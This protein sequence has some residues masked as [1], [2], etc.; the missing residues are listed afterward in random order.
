VAKK[1]KHQPVP[2]AP[3]GPPLPA[4]VK[5][6]VAFLQARTAPDIIAEIKGTPF[7]DLIRFHRDIGM[8]VR[9]LLGLWGRNPALIDSM[10]ESER[11]P[12]NAGMYIIEAWWRSLQD[13]E[14][15]AAPDRGGM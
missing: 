7:N 10:P 14:P 3:A 1:R 4:T 11:W 13:A 5:E 6:A 2:A 12:D 15:G 8:Q 9:N